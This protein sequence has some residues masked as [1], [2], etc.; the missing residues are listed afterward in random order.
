MKATYI[1]KNTEIFFVSASD[2]IN[3]GEGDW[4]AEL[5]AEQVTSSPEDDDHEQERQ[6]EAESLE[7]WY[8]WT[9]CPGCL[10][11]SDAFGPFETEE[12]A[13]QDAGGGEYEDYIM[14]LAEEL[15]VDPSDLTEESCEC[16][17]LKV[18]SHGSAE[19]AIGTDEEADEA[20]AE[21]VKESLWAFRASFI[22]SEYDLP[23]ELEEGIQALQE[24]KCESCNDVIH[25]LVEKT[26]GLDSFV[27]SAV[28]ADGR[29]HFLASYDG[30]EL[31]L[32]DGYVAFRI[33]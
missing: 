22:L 17:G 12:E 3:A 4:R 31:E 13:V 27:D 5:L 19:Y 21:A 14:A 6:C 7:G 8:W 24:T 1:P 32:Q 15:S 30:N 29:A 23:A 20:A 16:Y 25:A 10:P 26:C 11:D 2:F 33:N 28:S 9:C 18:L